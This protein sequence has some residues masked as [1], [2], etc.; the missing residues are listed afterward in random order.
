MSTGIGFQR[1]C[2][3]SEE[4]PNVLNTTFCVQPGRFDPAIFQ[5]A[6]SVCSTDIG[7]PPLPVAFELVVTP[8]LAF[9]EH[10]RQELTRTL[11]DSTLEPLRELFHRLNQGS[12]DHTMMERA[13]DDFLDAFEALHHLPPSVSVFGGARVKPGTPEY[14]MTR[15]MGVKLGELGFG[16]I[17]GG[18]PGVMEAAAR[19]GKEAGATTVGLNINLP[20][21][22]DPNPYLDLMVDFDYFFSRKVMFAKLSQGFVAGPGGFGTIDELF[23][24]LTLRQTGKMPHLPVVLLG[25]EFWEPWVALLKDKMLSMGYISQRDLD[26]IF[27]TDSPTEAAAFVLKHA[28]KKPAAS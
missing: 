21:E 17:T 20:H 2:V 3:T 25:K 28:P 6:V 4:G 24:I 14:E 19:G 15:E 8:P 23:E 7:R 16:V 27:V 18:G 13:L 11:S 1:I 10:G 12:V 9:T 22:Q 26:D 5:D